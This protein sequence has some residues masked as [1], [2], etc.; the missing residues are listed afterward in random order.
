MPATHP[1]AFRA[2]VRGHNPVKVSLGCVLKVP[3]AASKSERPSSGH[4]TCTAA[5]HRIACGTPSLAPSAAVFLPPITLS[6]TRAHTTTLAASNEAQCVSRAPSLGAATAAATAAATLEH[7]A[8]EAYEE[9]MASGARG[10]G[11]SRVLCRSPL[12]RS[13]VTRAGA[14]GR[15]QPPARRRPLQGSARLGAPALA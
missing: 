14:A 7:A 5:C 11:S 2:L 8:L 9:H 15:P 3:G 10:T 12:A 6:H 1:D 13:G 4:Q